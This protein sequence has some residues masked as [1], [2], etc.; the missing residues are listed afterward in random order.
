MLTL[1]AHRLPSLCFPPQSHWPPPADTLEMVSEVEP[2]APHGGA[3]SSPKQPVAEGLLSALKP[4]L[5]EALVSQV[6]ACYQFNVI[7]PSGPQSHGEG[8]PGGGRENR[9][10]LNRR[11]TGQI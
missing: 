5:S 3:V 1:A 9:R 10:T 2:S 7:L 4:I 8:C 6:G 11:R